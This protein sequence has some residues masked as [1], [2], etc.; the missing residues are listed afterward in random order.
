MPVWLMADDRIRRLVV[1][2]VLSWDMFQ[3][4]VATVVAETGNRQ[5]YIWH[6]LYWEN[7]DSQIETWSNLILVGTKY[8]FWALLHEL[9]HLAHFLQEWASLT[10]REPWM[11][12][13]WESELG[14]WRWAFRLAEELGVS[15]DRQALEFS[16]RCHLRWGDFD[17]LLQRKSLAPEEEELLRWAVRVGL[18]PI[19]KRRRPKA[20]RTVSSGAGH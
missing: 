7:E 9:G 10:P 17:P 18:W 6:V 12:P 8:S 19:I 11:I 1:E 4:A 16:L 3:E 15:I 2:H 14:A 13:H 5:S 20:L